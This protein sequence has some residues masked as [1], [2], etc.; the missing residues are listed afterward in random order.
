MKKSQ[1]TARSERT[2]KYNPH[3]SQ[4]LGT[5]TAVLFDLTE[6]TPICVEGVPLQKR[7]EDGHYTYKFHYTR[8]P[9]VFGGETIEEEEELDLTAWFANKNRLINIEDDLLLSADLPLVRPRTKAEKGGTVGILLFLRLPAA[10]RVRVHRTPEDNPPMSVDELR[11]ARCVIEG[12]PSSEAQKEADK[13]SL[14]TDKCYSF[15]SY[16]GEGLMSRGVRVAYPLFETSKEG[17]LIVPHE[18]IIL[19]ERDTSLEVIFR[20]EKDK[21]I[22]NWY[23]LFCTPEGSLF[24]SNIRHPQSKWMKEAQKILDKEAENFKAERAQARKRLQDNKKGI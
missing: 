21:S 23:D 2:G 12:R 19:M 3:S 1:D 15:P 4:D 10:G 13:R 24:Y 16:H 22:P 14:P 8:Q 20:Y 9:E 11:T 6:K 5:Y 18:Y 7:E 17:R